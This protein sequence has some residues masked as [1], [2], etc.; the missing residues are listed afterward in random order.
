MIQIVVAELYYGPSY[1][2][3]LGIVLTVDTLASVA[4]IIFL[5]KMSTA[6]GS[7]LPA[8]QMLMGLCAVAML[9]MLLLRTNFKSA[10]A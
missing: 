3:I 6:S 10:K 2:K 7:Y 8:I 1:G 9:S 5:G 4:G